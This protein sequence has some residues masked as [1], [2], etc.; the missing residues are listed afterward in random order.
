[1]MATEPYIS[2]LRGAILIQAHSVILINHLLS[3]NKITFFPLNLPILVLKIFQ[4]IDND[5]MY[6]QNHTLDKLHP[7]LG[8]CNLH[9]LNNQEHHYDFLPTFQ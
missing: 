1:M 3:F 9:T 4:L 6:H 5:H 7:K 8:F 2:I